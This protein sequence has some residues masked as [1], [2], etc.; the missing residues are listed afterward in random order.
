M[1]ALS[2]QA[3][4]EELVTRRLS[5]AVAVL[6]LPVHAGSVLDIWVGGRGGRTGR[7]TKPFPAY[8]AHGSKVWQTA[9]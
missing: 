5:V 8:K 2:T 6:C 3:H 1:A 9:W 4:G 7:G